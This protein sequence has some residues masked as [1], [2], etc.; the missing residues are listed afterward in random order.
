VPELGTFEVDETAGRSVFE[1]VFVYQKTFDYGKG[2]SRYRTPGI[3]HVVK[4]RVD[5]FLEPAQKVRYSLAPHAD[6]RRSRRLDDIVDE[7]FLVRSDIDGIVVGFED[8][9]ILARIVL[10][11]YH[12][13]CHLRIV[14]RGFVRGCVGSEIHVPESLLVGIGF[15]EFLVDVLVYLVADGSEILEIR[16]V[17]VERVGERVQEFLVTERGLVLGGFDEISPRFHEFGVGSH[18]SFGKV[19]Q[20][21]RVLRIRE[22]FENVNGLGV[23]VVRRFRLDGLVDYH[24]VHYRWD[25]DGFAVLLVSDTVSESTSLESFFETRSH[26]DMELRLVGYRGKGMQDVV[27]VL[28]TLLVVGGTEKRQGFLGKGRSEHVY[29]RADETGMYVRLPLLQ[30]CSYFPVERGQVVGLVGV[31]PDIVVLRYDEFS[32]SHVV[33]ACLFDFCREF[34]RKRDFF[35][36]V[37]YE[38]FEFHFLWKKVLAQSIRK[39]FF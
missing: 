27:L 10:P 15:S 2:R 14:V 3:Y 12:S 21:S 34:G 37:S 20:F 5:G 29:E 11:F 1:L 17:D 33:P 24:L 8:D 39:Y 16:R 26:L 25:F 13:A 18:V 7:A 38:E 9:G 19:A 23:R 36:C 4:E 31:L 6:F 28:E 35:S 32:G 22:Y 30:V